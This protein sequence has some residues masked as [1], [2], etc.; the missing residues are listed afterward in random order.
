MIS[1]PYFCHSQKEVKTD[2]NTDMPRRAPGP[3]N[4]L[5]RWSPFGMRNVETFLS[6]LTSLLVACDAGHLPGGWETHFLLTWKAL[7]TAALFCC[8]LCKLNRSHLAEA[9][10]EMVGKFCKN[11]FDPSACPPAPSLRCCYWSSAIKEPK[12]HG[13]RSQKRHFPFKRGF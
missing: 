3:E 6:L 1:F 4:S 12:G 13:K 5:L 10:G 8:K 7:H 9:A 11:L 2:G